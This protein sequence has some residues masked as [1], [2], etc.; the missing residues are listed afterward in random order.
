VRFTD[1]GVDHPVRNPYDPALRFHAPIR[2]ESDEAVASPK[3]QN[4]GE[5]SRRLRVEGEDATRHAR[6]SDAWRSAHEASSGPFGAR[7]TRA[8]HS[9]LIRVS[10]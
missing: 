2:V 3:A 5:V 10:R 7:R 6:D 8:A 9:P 1:F 4:E